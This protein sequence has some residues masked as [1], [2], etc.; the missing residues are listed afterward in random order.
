MGLFDKYKKNSKEKLLKFL[1]ERITKDTSL[2]SIVATFE[3]MCS[4]SVKEDMILFETG[5]FDFSGEERFYFSMVRQFPNDEE[6]FYQL[7]VD[8]L[9]EPTEKNKDY[10][11]TTWNEEI[12][13]N[14]FGYIKNSLEYKHCKGDQICNLEIY[15]DET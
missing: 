3:Q 11:Q 15:L 12:D 4:I 5:T 10:Q 1:Q 9:Y 2:E 14:I 7:H 6:E 8:V 13:E